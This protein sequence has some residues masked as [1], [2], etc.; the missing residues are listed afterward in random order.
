MSRNEGT[1]AGVGVLVTRPAH[2]ADGLCALLEGEGAR[3][4]RFPV[5]EI[6]DPED[7]QAAGEIVER[8][9]EFDIAVFI[10]PNA[11]NKAMNRI[12]AAGPLPEHLR[13]AAVGRGS[14]KELKRFGLSADIAPRQRF[15]SEALLEL[16]E[17]QD[18]AGKRIVIFRGDGGREL[19]AETLKERGAE[20]EYAE[21][22]RRA[23][24]KADVGALMRHWAR[25]DIDVITV[26]SNE[27]LHNL[28]DMVGQLGRQWLRKTP[29]IVVS[30]R[31]AELAQE[32]GFQA[33]TLVA[34]SAADEGLLQAVKDWRQSQT[35][36]TVDTP[37]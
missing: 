29:L 32:L 18:V 14:A 27:G 15:N 23:K 24:P 2:Q 20:V 7:P 5:L 12:R 30:E 26:T 17:M 36:T 37:S 8:L 9:A 22:Y 13:L 10:S 31:Q 21:V 19:L 33:R 6:V 11:V 1:L 34:E 28:F 3:C 16:P 4:V 25:G 35:A